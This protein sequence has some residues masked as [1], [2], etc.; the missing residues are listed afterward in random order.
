[1]FNNLNQFIMK[2]LINFFFNRKKKERVVSTKLAIRLLN[3]QPRRKDQE[4]K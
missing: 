1:M 3:E 2:K 4:R